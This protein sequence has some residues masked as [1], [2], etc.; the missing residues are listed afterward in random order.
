MRP[1]DAGELGLY[2][3]HVWSVVALSSDLD[4]PTTYGDLAPADLGDWDADELDLMIDE[5]RRQLDSLATQFE[6]TRSRGQFLFTLGVALVVPAGA[7]GATRF[8]DS[9]P[10]FMVWFLGF[11][12]LAVAVLGAAAVVVAPGQ[13]KGIDAVLLSHPPESGDVRLE[14]ASAYPR[15][16]TTS[17]DTV[18]VRHSLL[19]DSV[20]FLVIG[21]ALVGTATAT[22][23]VAL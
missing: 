12:S 3:R 1:F 18:R 14:L 20:W 4:V 2:F 22:A 9:F 17:A 11:L 13:L 7:V 5:G 10:L 21:L 19:R 6:Q 15:A 16:V 23:A 8:D